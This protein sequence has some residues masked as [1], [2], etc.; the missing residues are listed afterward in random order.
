[1]WAIMGIQ[2]GTRINRPVNA[3]RLVVPASK[4]SQLLQDGDTLP[5]LQLPASVLTPS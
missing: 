3:L 2:P 4:T 5:A 1:M